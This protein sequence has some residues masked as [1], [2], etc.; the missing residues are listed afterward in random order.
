MVMETCQYEK[1]D[2]LYH[3]VFE[4]YLYNSCFNSCRVVVS[5]IAAPEDSDSKRT[6]DSD[7]KTRGVR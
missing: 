4:F 5:K 7:V 2:V 3:V 6:C 1:L